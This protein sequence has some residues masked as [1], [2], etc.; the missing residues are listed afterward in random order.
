VNKKH[1]IP[2]P[3]R[4]SYLKH[5]RETN[6]QILLPIIL[7]SILMVGLF[8]LIT[9]ATFAQDGEVERWAA[10]STIWIVIPLKVSLLVALIITIGMVYGMGRLLNIAPDYTGLAQSYVLL[11]TTKIRHYAISFTSQII[12][13]RT[14]LD[15][16]HGFFKRN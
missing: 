4:A 15:T 8:A 16:L 9:Y 6:L 7:A 1:P 11:I 10:I 5:K 13:L 3:D 12:R 14:W 2:R